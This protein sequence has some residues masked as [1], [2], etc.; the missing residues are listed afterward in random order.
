MRFD[1]TVAPGGYAWWYVDAISADGARAI[2]I[3]AFIGSVFSPYYAW[4]GRRNPFD[5]CAINVAIYEPRRH[6]WAMTERGERAIDLDA[7]QFT[8]GPSR[9]HWSGDELAIEIDEKETPIPFPVRGTIRVRPRFVM[10][11]RF[12]IDRAGR[13][14]WRPI[15][16]CA[17][18]DVRFEA[19]D[20]VWSG[21]GYFDSN[22]GEEPLEDAFDYWDWSRLAVS[23]EAAAILYNCDLRNGEKTTLALRID[24]SGAQR[25]DPPPS[26]PLP[27]TRIWRIARRTNCDADARP[28]LVTTLEDVPFYSRSKVDNTLFGARGR[29]V[30]ESLSGARLRSP[31]V[32]AMLPFRMPRRSK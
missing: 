7:N 9:L 17:D 10:T 6:H 12:P 18:V 3:I 29:G 5:H 26:A 4:S 31:V 23:E 19:P 8:V 13:H 11:E 14:V 1:V 25:L 27:D 20:V 21:A 32:K 24:A 16:P 2:T 28:Q 22:I 30:H 15:A